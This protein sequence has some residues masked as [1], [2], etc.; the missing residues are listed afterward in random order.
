MQ[1][2]FKRESVYLAKL[3]EYAV[4]PL[5]ISADDNYDDVYLSISD[6]VPY[7]FTNEGFYGEQ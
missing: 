1:V 7:A 2:S 3:F 4:R 5:W 6:N